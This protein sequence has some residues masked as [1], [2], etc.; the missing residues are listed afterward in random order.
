MWSASGSSYIVHTH[1]DVDETGQSYFGGSNVY[2]LSS[3]GSQQTELSETQDPQE[4][5]GKAAD[6]TIQAIVW[7]P[8]REEFVLIQGFQPAVASLWSVDSTGVRRV[9]TFP[10]RTHRNTV[11]WNR[12][13]SLLC[14]GGFGNLAGDMDFWYRDKDWE[15]T[16]DSPAFLKCGSAKAPCTVACEWAPNG[17]HFITA[18]LSPRMRVDNAV[19]IWRG[20]CGEAVNNQRFQELFEA[21][22]KPTITVAPELSDEEIALA[23]TSATKAAP[24]PKRAA[25]RP[26]GQRGEGGDSVVAARMALNENMDSHIAHGRRVMNPRAPGGKTKGARGKDEANG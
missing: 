13:G 18:V 22:W 2:V 10:E 21:I 20:L 5:S 14:L 11:R 17:R 16:S 23:K 4:E 1:T 9:W 6:R 24:A 3:D 25:S 19:T 12:F 26:P 15:P 8:T 7:S